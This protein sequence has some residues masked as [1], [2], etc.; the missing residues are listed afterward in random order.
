[1]MRHGAVTTVEQR[2]AAYRA[3]PPD[4]LIDL[5]DFCRA[6]ETCFHEDPR[7]H[8]AM[9]GRREVWL[10]IQDHIHL[11]HDQLIALRYGRPL[12]GVGTA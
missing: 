6:S 3:I 4:A 11:T 2:Q 7:V 8:A 1:M 5:A 10:R 12:H 9:E